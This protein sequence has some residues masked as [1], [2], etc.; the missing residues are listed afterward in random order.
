M[1]AFIYGI[2]LPAAAALINWMQACAMATKNKLES[3][4]IQ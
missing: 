4:Q 3:S 1:I 2:P